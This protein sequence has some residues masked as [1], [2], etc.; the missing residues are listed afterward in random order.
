[1]EDLNPTERAIF[2]CFS[3]GTKDAGTIIAELE[4]SQSI[5]YRALAKLVKLGYIELDARA[6]AGANKKFY[7]AKR[8]PNSG[9][10]FMLPNGQT[11]SFNM[12]LKGMAMSP[13]PPKISEAW[14]DLPK[15][16]AM[17]AFCAA[18]E[19]VN[20]GSISEV[21]LLEAKVLV[22]EYGQV[23]QS[24]YAI[25]AQMLQDEQL[26]HPEKL[27]D[28]TLRKT[29]FFQTPSDIQALGK[30]LLDRFVNVTNNN[31]NNNEDEIEGTD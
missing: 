31:A 18:A 2:Q 1:M 11:V 28:G 7:Q 25:V 4:F 12:F 29:D 19:M 30:L 8:L 22:Q 9:I 5:V 3:T 24:Q 15:A 14:S 13:N 20:P 23:L 26:W 16:F 21:E 10:T 6:T 27:V 17:L